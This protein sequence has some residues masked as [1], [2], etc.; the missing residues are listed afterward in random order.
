ME[1]IQ[2][3]IIR[4]MCLY[5][6][7]S[8]MLRI[9][10]VNPP[11]VESVVGMLKNLDKDKEFASFGSVG[12][13]LSIFRTKEAPSDWVEIQDKSLNDGMLGKIKGKKTGRFNI[14]ITNKKLSYGDII[15]K[16][17]REQHLLVVFDPNEKEV[18][19]ARNS[20]QIHI[21]PLCV[22][23][24]YEYNRIQGS[25][26]IRPANEGGIFADYAGI[27]EKLREQPSSFGHRSVF[28][29]SPLREETYKQLL[30]RAD[31]LMILD[32]NLK[33]WDI[34]L[35]SES[36]KLFYKGYDTLFCYPIWV[37]PAASIIHSR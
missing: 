19:L 35:R 23:K 21:H 27:L 12:I 1:A 30:G 11:S 24:V 26:R 29:N 25:V 2:Q 34:S 33:S 20:R 14:S 13:D 15:R 36:E 31:W 6:H 5:P 10:F 8:M 9:A 22:P 28:V 4:Y 32:Q 18:N 17:K 16:L 7:S 37:Y 3:G